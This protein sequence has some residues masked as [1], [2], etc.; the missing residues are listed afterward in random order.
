MEAAWAVASEEDW[1]EALEET[2][3][4]PVEGRGFP[5]AS[6]AEVEADKAPLDRVVQVAAALEAA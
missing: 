6:V 2:V 3:V 4:P 1:V 5:A